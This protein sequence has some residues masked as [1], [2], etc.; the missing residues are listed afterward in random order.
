MEYKE[1]I[2]TSAQRV[3]E[4]MLNKGTYEQWVAKSWPGSTY[5]GRWVQGEKI[6]FTGEDGGGT[7]A[8][9][10]AVK[11]YEKVTARHIAI[12]LSGG[13]ED[14]TSDMAKGWIGTVEEYRFAESNGKTTLTV[15][16]TTNPEWRKMFD[17]GWPAA[18]Q[19]LKK[20][21]EPALKLS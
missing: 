11:P 19:E 15:L 17:E 7:L 4:V 3:W 2:N 6:R 1:V 21:A 20:L 9:L 8:E 14:R 12:L 5:Q 13:V 10:A 18:L 16:I